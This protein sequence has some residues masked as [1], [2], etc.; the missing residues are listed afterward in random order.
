MKK[1]VIGKVTSINKDDLVVLV[2]KTS[3]KCNKKDISDYNC[4]LDSMF[5]VNKRYKFIVLRN[6]DNTVF[7]S[8]KI[9]RPKLIKNRNSPTPTI[10]GFK[11]LSNDMHKNLKNYK[12]D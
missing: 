8:Y 5:T 1:V 4:N 7:L 12:I 10:S 3:F 6:K 11:N 2:N 9:G